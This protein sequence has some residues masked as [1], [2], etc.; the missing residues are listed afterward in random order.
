MDR[1]DLRNKDRLTYLIVDATLKLERAQPT[2]SNKI[3]FHYIVSGIAL[4]SNVANA[5]V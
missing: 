1:S 5:I 3:C 4:P 2:D